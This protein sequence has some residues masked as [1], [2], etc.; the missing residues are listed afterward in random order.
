MTAPGYVQ[1]DPLAGASEAASVQLAQMVRDHNA[2]D[3]QQLAL[4]RQRQALLPNDAARHLSAQ[5]EI[6]ALEAKIARNQA[7][8][9]LTDAERLDRALAGEVDHLGAETTVDQEV[10][11]RDFIAAIQDDLA[12]G[13]RPELV[14]AYY[15]TGKSD[16]PDG[17]VYADIWFEKYAADPEMQ[18][19][20][21]E[22][23]REISRQFRCACI[24]AAGSH[25]AT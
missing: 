15:A 12:L 1:P 9:V 18:R 20:H 8:A 3:E 19:R 7:P 23:D 21:R 25:E 13:V 22:G 10:R 6:A 5:A 4:A 14:R 2:G 11:A 24:Y 17:H 16:A